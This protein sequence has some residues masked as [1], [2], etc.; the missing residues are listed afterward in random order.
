MLLPIL[1]HPTKLVCHVQECQGTKPRC[2]T[3]VMKRSVS[4]QSTVQSKSDLFKLN[5]FNLRD[6]LDLHIIT[7][8][9]SFTQKLPLIKF[10]SLW[11]QLDIE[12]RQ[13]WP[14][15][16]FKKNLRTV[17][18]EKLPNVVSCQNPFCSSCYES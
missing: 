18:L 9:L 5:D 15:S 6:A 16:L 8:K 1:L 10:P 14:P 17:M 13:T 4:K 3:E 2:T 7:P 12:V 11:N